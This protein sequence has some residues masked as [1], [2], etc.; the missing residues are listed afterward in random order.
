[1][2]IKLLIILYL[3]LIIVYSLIEYSAANFSDAI[4]ND[5]KDQGKDITYFVR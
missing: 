4:G 5:L 3:N 1:M 2:S